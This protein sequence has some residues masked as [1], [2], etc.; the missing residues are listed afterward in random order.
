MEREI[1][2]AMVMPAYEAPVGAGQRMRTPFVYRG[3]S[4]NPPGITALAPPHV[5]WSATAQPTLAW[6]VDRVPSE[7]AFYLTISDSEDEPLVENLRLPLPLAGGVQNTSLAGLD[8]ELRRGVEYRWSI[9]HRL[10]EESP[11]TAYAFGWIEA[12]EMAGPIR[13]R[14]G[15]AA[16]GSRP[17]LLAREGY[18]YDALQA[19]LDLVARHPLDDRP[20]NALRALLAQG[21]VSDLAL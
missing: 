13:D 10:D 18:W 21:G 3:S 5:A 14:A 11:P 20:R 17:D 12:V 19:T 16:P 6:H 4:E 1:L 8:V 15:Q 2:V 9:A 7:G